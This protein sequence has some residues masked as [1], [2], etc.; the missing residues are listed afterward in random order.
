MK[1]TFL[2]LMAL[3]FCAF[4]NKAMGQTFN[5][6]NPGYNSNVKA[7]L[8][9]G[10][11]T[12][13][14][15]GDMC[16]F[17][18]SSGDGITST[19]G[20]EA[21]WWFDESTRD[22]IQNVVIQNGVT[23]IG[24]RAFKDCSYLQTIT[25]PNTVTIIG[26]RA[27]DNC[28]SLQ[29]IE[30]PSSVTEIEGEAFYNCS[31]LNTVTIENGTTEL[32]F[33]SF[34]Y[35]GN[36]YSWGTK[37]D[38]FYGC[39][40]Q[41]LHFGRTLSSSS[42]NPFNGTSIQ[43]LTIG[44]TVTSLV[45]NAF[46]NCTG[47]ADVTLED[48]TTSLSF[49]YYSNQF[50]NCPI[51]TFYWGRNLV[52]YN[53]PCANKATLTSVS[54]GNNVNSIG[55]GDFY[56]CT[57]LTSI[58][59]PNSITS[60]GDQ[61]FYYC[62][63]LKS[64]TFS[65]NIASIGNSAFQYSGL[66]NI[67]IPNTVSSIG[68]SA[69][70]NCTGLADVTLEDGTTPLS[71]NFYS[72][73]FYNC[74]IKTFYWGRNLVQYNSPCAN[75]AT[76]T[77]V[78]IGNNVNSI[79]DGDFYN[80]TSLASITI[81]SS[82]TSIGNQA[83]YYCSSLKNIVI[84]SSIASIGSS[85]FQYSG[86][87]NIS[88]PNTVSSIGSS[89]FANCTGLIDVTLEDGTTVLSFNYYSDQFYNCPIKTF[90]WG[91]NLAQYGSPV[92]GK[93]TLTTLTIG[94]NITSIGNSDF[95]GCTGLTQIT[96]KPTT[97]P[98]IYSNTFNGVSK[99]IPVYIDCDFLTDYQS[100]PYWEDF[101]NYQCVSSDATLKSLTVSEE[102][103]TPA[104]DADITEYTVDVTT[105][106]SSITINA[107]ANYS[108]ATVS[109]DGI[110]SLNVGDNTFNIVVTAED[111]TTTNTYT[112][113]VTRATTTGTTWQIGY[114]NPA[115]VTA[116]LDNGTLTISGMGAMQDWNI[117]DGIHSPWWDEKDDITNVVIGNEIT[118]IGYSAFFQCNS[119][120][121]ITIPN[122]VTT[123]GRFA[124]Q[125]SG[126]SSFTIPG[127]VMEIEACAFNDCSNLKTVTIEDG[128]KLRFTGPKTNDFDGHFQNTPIETLYLGRDLE[129][130]NINGDFS[131][132]F[133]F[134]ENPALQTLT[135][136]KNVTTINAS[137]FENCSG[138]TQITS[139]PTTPPT[140]QS[141][142][143]NGV[144]KDIPV[145]IDCD[146]L[147]AYQSALYWKDFTNYQCA[148]SD[149]TL[150]SLTVSEGTLT[151]AF[152]AGITEYTV[153]VANDVSS[154][155][156][157][158]LANYS[159]AIVSGD[160]T[161]SLN[162]GDNPFSIVVT[163]EDGTT[164]NT[165]KV[166]VTRASRTYTIST[167]PNPSNG[168]VT[169]GGGSYTSGESCTVHATANTGYSFVNWTESGK[170]VS[171]TS[172]YTFLVSANRN[173][174]AHFKS[175][176]ATLKS[177]TVSKGTLTPAFNLN[178]KSYTLD[179][180]NE[181]TSIT[182]NA[183]ANYSAATVR[184]NGTKSLNVGEN[185]FNIVVTAEDGTTTNTYKVLVTR[186]SSTT[187]AINDIAISTFKIFP[188]PA[189]DEIFIQSA[190]PVKK[191]E[192]YSLAGVLRLTDSNF[193]G[194]IS[195]ASLPQGVYMVKVYTDTGLVVS[196]VV[197]E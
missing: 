169:S 90:Y 99:D 87:I 162:V 85:A 68:S 55:D 111:G 112:V 172:S 54:I 93:T 66:T 179:V 14:G 21:P 9:D 42:N 138:L 26:R 116:T 197:K 27:F 79:G 70:S 134:S 159:A 150:K 71:F 145:Y 15:T 180:P 107:T 88:I 8:S 37:T 11:L 165:Y 118:R 123:I 124:F 182:I 156:I 100:V 49:N 135:I 63:S 78:T 183:I 141:N 125:G 166:V 184:G 94:S 131:D 173:L 12:I 129:N 115:D 32:N 65:S 25:I 89:A 106:I 189:K 126:L 23:N 114:P 109:G 133:P 176:D 18:D 74:P 43:T 51:K 31:G 178:T 104:F 67:T 192:I 10:T 143:F 160:G 64:I 127:N 86:L 83:F 110:K 16:D 163:A 13:S 153:D 57:G 33:S 187:D 142:T 103:L 24:N 158:T 45:Y 146:F 75:K 30:I 171:T 190:S 181:V 72:D 120:S 46:S 3:C 157:N 59:I 177:L 117:D 174:D 62:S 155:T 130:E 154:I 34:Y 4:M 102:T 58:T 29:E 28:P 47:L 40:L 188:N 132:I 36:E 76:L 38:W 95:Y 53:S 185:T 105:D 128:A 60:I 81:P 137:S 98:T 193:S 191:V 140:I 82:I 97:P 164:T 39:P 148:S 121:S 2:L 161:K 108:A 167:S 186:E 168:G 41:T 61:A 136:G 69:F 91:R 92:E 19:T 22:A 144:S 20:G 73:Q 35:S 175:S 77:S 147:T 80:C 151:P 96:S 119:L 139:N 149:A 56:N 7:T 6:G 1:K 84:P 195:I 196:K 101:T 44:N 194:K 17:W 48:G 170:V 52:Q 50:S 5:I 152:D 122:S 113:V